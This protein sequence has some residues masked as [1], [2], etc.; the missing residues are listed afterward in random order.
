MTTTPTKKLAAP[1]LEERCEKDLLF[2]SQCAHCRGL[3]L[4]PALIGLE[5]VQVLRRY[6]ARADGNCPSCKHE[7]AK[8]ERLAE[9]GEGV[10]VC[11]RCAP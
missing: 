11:E 1:E 9:V 5:E 8:G 6:T 3:T 2:R 10:R 4:D 7:Y